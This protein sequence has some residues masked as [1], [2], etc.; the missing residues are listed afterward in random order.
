M[1]SFHNDPA[2]KGKYVARLQV[3]HAADEIVQG[4]YWENGKGCAVGCTIHGSDHK[5]YED[6]LGL[7]EWLARLEDVIFEGLPNDK[8]KDFACDFLEAIPVGK[9]LNRV[10]WQFCAFV[11]RE[12]ITHVM[13]LDISDQLKKQVIDAIRVCLKLH[14]DAIETGEWPK[15]AAA[16]AARSAARSAAE[17][18]AWSAA[19]L[20]ARSAAH[21]RYAQELLRLLREA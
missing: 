18:A 17:L 1:L 4:K 3:H 12:N 9:D 15:S 7:P 20:A 6:E 5:A 21:E 13:L 2:V 14:E 10:K 8:A 16:L 11:L 19:E